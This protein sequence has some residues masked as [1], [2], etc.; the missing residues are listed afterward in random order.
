MSPYD[1]A[2][3]RLEFRGMAR[4]LGLELWPCPWFSFPQ[5]TGRV[6]GGDVFGGDDLTEQV[7][8][9]EL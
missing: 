8:A 5:A 2:F 1:G 4:A 6:G 9:S 7:Q 3:I